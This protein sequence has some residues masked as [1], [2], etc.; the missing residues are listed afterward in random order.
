M[1]LGV[2]I[3]GLHLTAT[4][5]LSGIGFILSGLAG[6]FAAP[7]L[8]YLRGNLSYRMMAAVVLLAVAAI[9]AVIGGG[10]YWMHMKGFAGWS[11]VVMQSPAS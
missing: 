5:A 7:T 10:G 6:V 3:I 11:P 9:W 4:P 8:L 2:R 1:L